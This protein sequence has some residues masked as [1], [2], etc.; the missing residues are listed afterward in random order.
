MR[1]L[2]RAQYAAAGG[3]YDTD[4]QAFFTATGISDT[5]IKDAV[6]ALVVGLKADSVWTKFAAIYPLV[7]GTSSTHL[8]NLKNPGTHNITW[9]GSV[10]HNSNGITSDGSTG[11][12]NTNWN[13]ST[14]GANND[15]HMSV[16]LR[17]D[18]DDATRVYGAS[19]GGSGTLMRK[20]GGNYATKCQETTE[21]TNAVSNSL[22]YFSVNRTASTGYRG[23]QNTTNFNI[24]STSEA[25]VNLNVYLSCLN[26]GGTAVNF[27]TRNIA[28]FAIG[29]GL[30]QT[31]DGNVQ[32]RVETFQDALSRGVV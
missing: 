3:S 19:S 10:T 30:T 1:L 21:R 20:N 7:G 29:T 6:D 2:R 32:S 31:E 24:T 17:T 5:T 12:G 27:T 8:V 16:Y 23:R 25:R 15:E 22:G 13:I 11:Y 26:S 9:N 14:H 18:A 4:A 28:W